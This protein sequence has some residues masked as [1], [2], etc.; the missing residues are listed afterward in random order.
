MKKMSVIVFVVC[1]L[2]IGISLGG[3]M[4]AIQGVAAA[5]NLGVGSLAT[6]SVEISK[7][8]TFEKSAGENPL[9]NRVKIA[10]TVTYKTASIRGSNF[11][12]M[13]MVLFKFR[14]LDKNGKE[15]GLVSEKITLTDGLIESVESGKTYHFVLLNEKVPANQSK[16]AVASEYVK[17]GGGYFTDESG[18]WHQ[19]E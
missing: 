14:L 12:N 18:E 8:V 3:C 2:F 5:V 13:Q 7:K 9:Y 19:V 17:L 4:L 10:G 16:S 1:S 15:V 11:I 6:G